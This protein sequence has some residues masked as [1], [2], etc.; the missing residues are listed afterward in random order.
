[1]QVYRENWIKYWRKQDIDFVITP[2]FG[3]Q[4]VPHGKSEKTSLAAAYSFI[5][6]IL[7]MSVGTMPVTTV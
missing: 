4:A 2:S 3:C 5:W 7:D 6:N 1:M